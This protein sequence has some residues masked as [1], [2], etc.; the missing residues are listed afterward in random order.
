[1]SEKKNNRRKGLAV[2]LGIVG[3]AGLTLAAASQLT[4]NVNSNLQA[5]VQVLAD[6]QPVGDDITVSFGTPTFA[7]GAYEV[8]TATFGNVNPNCFPLNYVANLVDE[9]GDS[10]AQVTGTVASASF[11]VNFASSDVDVADVEGVAL[12]IH[13]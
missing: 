6:C 9:N 11:A 7:A 2:A 4:L 1:M 10:L 5:G 12:T 8:T 3:V 13:S